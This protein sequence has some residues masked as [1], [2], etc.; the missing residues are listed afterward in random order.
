VKDGRPT[1]AL[2][3]VL[4]LSASPAIAQ[5]TFDWQLHGLATVFAHRFMGGGIGLG[6]RPPGRTRISLA[7]SAGDLDGTAAG[8]IEGLLSFHLDPG[9]ER[10]LSPYSAAGL[11]AN[12]TRHATKGYV[13][14]LLGVEER[15][16]RRSGLFVE[17]GIG[18]GMR[19]AAGYRIRSGKG[20]NR[21]PRPR[22]APVP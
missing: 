20:I 21:G 5:Q 15:P 19:L 18:G 12:V 6:V 2:A 9:K 13:E 4:S 10:G 8:R 14:V 17:V 1:V 3:L 22:A 7:A 11:A 16:G